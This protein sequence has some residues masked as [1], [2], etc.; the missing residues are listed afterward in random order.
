VEL[1]KQMAAPIEAALRARREGSPDAAAG[2]TDPA[3][4]AWVER[5]GAALRAGD[6]ISR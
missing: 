2:L 6:P 5:L 1:G 4:R 3:T